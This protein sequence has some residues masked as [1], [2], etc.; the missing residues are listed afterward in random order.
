M[1]KNILFPIL[2]LGTILSSYAQSFSSTT[3][4]IPDNNCADFIFTV[5]NIGV[6]GPNTFK[7]ISLNIAHLWVE[8]LDISLIAPNGTTINLSSDNGLGG[9]N[10][11]NTIFSPT[12]TASITTG[13]PPFTGTF[14][15]E[16]NLGT[17]A[18]INAN[19]NWILRICDDDALIFGSLTNATLVFLNSAPQ[20]MSYQ[21]VVRS[22]S[23]QLLVNTLVGM[24][25]SVL[26]GGATGTAVYVETQTP[27][28]NA[29]GL[30]T[31]QIG[32]GS[33]VSGSFQ[34]ISW[35]TSSKFIKTE[36]DPSGGTNYSITGTSELLSVPYALFSLTSAT[37]LS[38]PEPLQ[39]QTTGI[40][41]SNNNTGNVGIGTTTPTVPL[42]F[43]NLLGNKIS[44]YGSGNNQY[45]FGIQPGL[46]QMYA[47]GANSA[48][49]AFGG[50]DSTNFLEKMRIKG[51]GNVGIG[52]TNP[53]TKLEVNGFTKLG[54]DAPAIKVKKL[55]GTTG[56][57]ENMTISIAHGLT[58][59]KIL[60]VTVLVDYS[61]NSFVPA[62]YSRI[63]YEFDFYISL[64][65]I[66]IRNSATNSYLILSKP[67]KVLVTYEE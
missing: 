30:A 66:Y 17:L 18:G 65:N 8:D 56:S 31:L 53:T 5:S 61:T 49:I 3:G 15:P 26:E 57:T 59:S 62:S 32:N 24:K 9:D 51:N 37:A 28:T 43:A 25:I 11:T 13:S 12:A 41:I 50:S 19:G 10:Y 58:D 63:G 34:T 2:F 44:L 45:G 20:K 40:N 23:N 16:G 48:D 4:P 54:S 46:L 55:T 14:L 64:G 38:N 35:G 27:T 29:N 60:S 6:L 42:Q 1:K 36:I 39:W 33:I 47:D 52:I 21:A 67:I 22:I 7:E